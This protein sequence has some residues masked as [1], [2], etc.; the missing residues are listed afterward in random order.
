MINSLFNLLLFLLC[1]FIS[2]GTGFAINHHLRIK[3]KSV[4]ELLI[5]SAGFGFVIIIYITTLFS[6]LNNL[7]QVEVYLLTG[8][9]FIISTYYSIKVASYYR[10]SSLYDFQFL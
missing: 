7:G 1:L 4:E 10:F 6:L 8:I 5:L 9:L 3:Y 2:I